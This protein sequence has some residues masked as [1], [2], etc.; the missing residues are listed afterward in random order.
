LD[1]KY[2]TYSHRAEEKKRVGMGAD[3][4]GWP[5]G[6]TPMGIDGVPMPLSVSLMDGEPRVS[7]ARRRSLVIRDDKKKRGNV[8]SKKREDQAV[9]TPST[10]PE[11]L[12]RSGARKLEK[13]PGPKHEL[14]PSSILPPRPA[15]PSVVASTAQTIF[16]TED[17]NGNVYVR[18]AQ[19]QAVHEEALRF[20][21]TY[22]YGYHYLVNRFYD[23][24]D[25]DV[26]NGAD[27]M[28]GKIRTFRLPKFHFPMPGPTPHVELRGGGSGKTALRVSRVSLDEA[29]A[30]AITNASCDALRRASWGNEVKVRSSFSTDSNVSLEVEREL[31]RKECRW[32]DEDGERALAMAMH[33]IG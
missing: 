12:P 3:Q 22:G 7:F 23:H 20:Q 31:R 33:K 24:N 15:A 30:E 9:A 10:Y 14:E 25:D 8:N 4:S 16:P 26:P 32:R 18:T 1:P 27:D 17:P 28:T 29:T 2:K 6:G 5:I 21:Q 11:G 13:T 19:E